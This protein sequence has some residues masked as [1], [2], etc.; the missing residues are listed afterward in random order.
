MGEYRWAASMV[1]S[2][3]AVSRN[4][5]ATFSQKVS[6]VPM[7]KVVEYVESTMEQI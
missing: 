1:G 4:S 5:V 6:V 2:F 3:A 7:G